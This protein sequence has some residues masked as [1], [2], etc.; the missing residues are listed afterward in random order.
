MSVTPS[1]L[2]KPWENL[3]CFDAAVDLRQRHVHARHTYSGLPASKVFNVPMVGHRDRPDWDQVR[4]AVHLLDTLCRCRGMRVLL[5]CHNGIN[6]TGTVYLAW[7][8]RNGASMAAAKREWLRK[9]PSLPR[10]QILLECEKTLGRP[11][12]EAVDYRDVLQRR[13]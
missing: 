5:H 13:P 4:R 8:V 12:G 3:A 2:P 11:D 9:R 6:R 7:C 10:L 1:S